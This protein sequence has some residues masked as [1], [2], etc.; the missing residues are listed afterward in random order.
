MPKPVTTLR[1]LLWSAVVIFALCVF[2][3]L[4]HN[5]LR[6]ENEKSRDAQVAKVRMHQRIVHHRSNPAPLISAVRSNDFEIVKMF[7][8]E[9]IDVNAKHYGSTPLHFAAQYNG[10]HEITSFLVAEGADI[11]AEDKDGNTP[12]HIAVAR[13]NLATIDVLIS[14][15]ADV[16]AKNLR[17][18]T[19]LHEVIASFGFG[20]FSGLG[21]GGFSQPDD[22]Y[23]AERATLYARDLEL[24]KS[25]IS[26]GAD[27]NANWGQRTPLH[28]AVDTRKNAEIIKFL[29]SAGADV[30]VQ[31]ANG[32]TPLHFA[33][34]A[35][36]YV[37]KNWTAQPSPPSLRK[38]EIEVVQFL[39][40]NSANVNAKDKDGNTPLHLAVQGREN[41][42]IV[43]LLV[44]AGADVN[45]KDNDGKT[46]LDIAKEVRGNTAI[47]E[48]L[49]GIK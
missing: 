38:G 33:A 39:V 6:M 2:A 42:E 49:S 47:V 7:V 40:D 41:I 15:E 19:P 8:S 17:G 22:R 24:A 29:L 45:A 31:D 1:S 18:Y 14:K 32:A 28:L 26:A 13:R 23:E 48:F 21:G 36:Y 4:W 12:L 10:S 16:N 9:G 20:S 25:L 46:P 5:H 11:N 44:S 27:V 34:L 37:V 30:N 3:V 43:Q 35:Y